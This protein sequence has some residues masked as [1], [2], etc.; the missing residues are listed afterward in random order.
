MRMLLG[1]EGLR[2]CPKNQ[3]CYE[4]SGR[5]ITK[6]L[7]GPG[8]GSR[9]RVPPWARTMDRAMASPSP[10][11][12]VS[13]ARAASRRTKGSKIRSASAGGDADAGVLDREDGLAVGR[14]ER[15]LDR[16]ARGRVL[17]RVLDE[18]AHRAAERARVTPYGGRSHG[19]ELHVHAG[20]LGQPGAQLERF[21]D[22]G[23]ELDAGPR[24][25]RSGPPRG[26]G[27]RG[28]RPRG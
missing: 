9:V 11:P 1:K 6:Q 3:G 2:N 14:P 21:Q 4:A 26:T 27:A 16:A 8:S 23:L 12:P 22:E 24:H 28:P 25:L 18:V 13:R 15:E 10:V 5:L 17:D 20:A 19:P 7:P